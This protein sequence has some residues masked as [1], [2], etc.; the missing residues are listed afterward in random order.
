[1][2]PIHRRQIPRFPHT[3]SGNSFFC[4]AQRMT[5]ASYRAHEEN[6]VCDMRILYQIP[7]GVKFREWG[8]KAI[9]ISYSD[10]L[11]FHLLR[12]LFADTKFLWWR[13]FVIPSW[14]NFFVNSFSHIQCLR[15]TTYVMVCWNTV[16]P[17]YILIIYIPTRYVHKYIWH[18][19]ACPWTYLRKRCMSTRNCALDIPRYVKF[20]WVKNVTYRVMSTS[21]CNFWKKRAKRCRR[22]YKT[23]GYLA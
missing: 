8:A 3:V 12:K 5:T 10:I 9:N 14:G 13:I 4:R 1:M 21:E 20:F 18:N 6:E 23:W 17:W 22:I 16:C 11:Y 19:N 7:K 2:D 15:K